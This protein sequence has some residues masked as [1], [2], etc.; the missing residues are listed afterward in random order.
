MLSMIDH[1]V[2]MFDAADW[3]AVWSSSMSVRTRSLTGRWRI[4]LERER[5]LTRVAQDAESIGCCVN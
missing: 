5:M 4:K 2:G 3:L 1:Q